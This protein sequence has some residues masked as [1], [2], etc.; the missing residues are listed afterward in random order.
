M[1][2][3]T[4]VLTGRQ[5][6]RRQSRLPRGRWLWPGVV[7]ALVLSTAAHPGSATASVDD[8][9]QGV[10][11]SAPEAVTAAGVASGGRVHALADG[12]LLALSTRVV[13]GATQVFA[14]TRPPAGVWTAGEQL[15]NFAPAGA[16]PDGS[17]AWDVAP[18]GRAVLAWRQYDSVDAETELRVVR[19]T[20]QGSWTAPAVLVDGRPDTEHREVQ[21]RPG[22]L[23]AVDPTGEGASVAWM[24]DEADESASDDFGP[25]TEVYVK[26]WSGVAWSATEEVS[27]EVSG[28]PVVCEAPPQ[29]CPDVEGD[30]LSPL[31]GIDG[32]GQE[33]IGW[34]YRAST[35]QDEA[36]G[37]VMLRGPEGTEL[38]ATSSEERP[39]SFVATHLAADP[40][41]GVAVTWQ[42]TWAGAEGEETWAHQQGPTGRATTRITPASDEGDVRGL[43][44]R[45][46]RGLVVVAT[47]DVPMVGGRPLVVSRLG[48]G[49]P[50]WSPAVALDDGSPVAANGGRVL[51][52]PDGRPLIGWSTAVFPA[53]ATSGRVA[54][55]TGGGEWRSRSA[56]GAVSAPS[57]TVLD[58]LPDGGLLLSWVGRAEGED[59]SRLHV[60]TAG[61]LVSP[62]PTTFTR[63]SA[64][65]VKGKARVGSTLK[66]RPGRWDPEPTSVSFRWLANNK[67]IRRATKPTLRIRKAQEGKRLACRITLRRDGVETRTVTVKVRGRVR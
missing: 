11:W 64:P 25:D 38:L 32:D 28:P 58:A 17:F 16:V 22:L 42:S 26:R 35:A 18:D 36:Q 60:S 53:S 31:L 34:V 2:E 47:G 9:W 10:E 56:T 41:G 3:P 52:L 48:A 51:V 37:G 7:T 21:T 45:G 49:D 14:S 6:V 50:A 40:D 46:G 63:E 19:R 66:A 4:A 59:V 12:T 8:P 44:V 61:A 5:P 30:A 62:A 67:P 15:T 55:T 29:D 24:G 27:Q 33:W 65:S 43:A 57:L 13:G 20:A 39:T 54:T 23:V 1:S